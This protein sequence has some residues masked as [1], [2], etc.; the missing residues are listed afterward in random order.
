MAAK[1]R[2]TSAALSEQLFERY[3]EFLFYRAVHLLERLNKN[4]QGFGQTLMPSQEPVRFKAKQGFSFP[5]S[6]ISFL[7]DNGPDLAP[8]MEVS[9]MG[10]TGPSGVLPQWYSQ[11]ILERKK[12]KDDTLADFL[13]L[14]HHRL[15]TLFYL[16]WKKHRFPENYQ[17]GAADRLSR[18]LLCL[19][20]LGTPGLTQMIGLPEE[21]LTFYSG[22][23]SRPIASAVSIEAA[24]AYFSDS[25]VSVE[26]YVER[27]VE[28]EPQD[29]TQLGKTNARLGDDAIC[30]NQVWEGQTKF[31][32]HLGPVDR[33]K[34][35]R[36]MPTGDLLLPIFSLVR[37]MVGIEYE[38]EIR[39]YLKKE[40]V[41]LCQLGRTGAD[42]PMLGWTTWVSSPGY[43][44]E[45]DIFFT[46]QEYDLK[47][48]KF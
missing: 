34:F 37:Y 25:R 7:R 9:F 26:Q 4:R 3:Y 46:F 27:I 29:Q 10:L 35:V 14:F 24:V 8:T 15:I 40:D 6:D 11:L 21:S 36:L 19:S 20:G 1:K 30:G 48:V 18:Y 45:T 23:F 16:V 33:Q 22:L 13:D 44:Y 47:L 38:F 17:F 28:L 12:E 2:K 41:P 31:R 32:L 39:I 43:A 42:T 5:P